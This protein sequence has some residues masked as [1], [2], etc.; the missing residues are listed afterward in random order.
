MKRLIRI[1][2]IVLLILLL[3]FVFFYFWGSRPNYDEFSYSRIHDYSL[4]LTNNNTDT[5]TIVTYNIGYLSGMNNNI[6]IRAD[7]DLYAENLRKIK[8]FF[9]RL[10]PT[11]IGFQEIDFFSRRSFFANQMDSIAFYAGYNYSSVAINWDKKY[12]PFPYWPPTVHFG[13]ILSG[14]GILSQ[15][16]ITLNKR[17]VLPKPAAN[18]FY[19]NAFYL[20]RLIQISEVEVNNQTLI[21]INVHLE[22]F[23][24]VTREEQSKILINYIKKYIDQYPLLVV[25]DFNSRPP[26]SGVTSNSEETIR[27]ILKIPGMVTAITERVYMEDPERYMTFSSDKPYEKIDYIFYNTRFIRNL[28]AETLH[29]AG[30]A[31]DHLPVFMKFVLIND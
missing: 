20:D 18:P 4:K 21:I 19:Y 31:S 10:H 27:L 30:M 2:L 25:G 17:I 7:R 8:S 14:Q 11:F 15:F 26:F 28:E 22:A 16:P 13:R 23:D 1:G 29:E 24:Q 9:K 5:F 6:S 3:F 12:V